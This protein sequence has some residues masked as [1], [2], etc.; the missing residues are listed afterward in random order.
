MKLI[1]KL[2]VVLLFISIVGCGEKDKQAKTSDPVVL[3]T[4]R[5]AL[6]KAKKVEEMLQDAA[7]QER[8]TIDESTNSQR[9]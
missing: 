7:E 5:E 9:Q 6:D 1:I 3:K 2:T 8:K 4:Q